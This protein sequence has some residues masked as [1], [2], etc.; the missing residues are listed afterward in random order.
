MGL[1]GGGGG[2]GVTA[3]ARTLHSVLCPCTLHLVLLSGELG[4]KI[5]TNPSNVVDLPT[6]PYHK[7]TRHKTW[8]PR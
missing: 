8:V 5:N 6:D 7:A 1:H 3:C 4:W 2:G